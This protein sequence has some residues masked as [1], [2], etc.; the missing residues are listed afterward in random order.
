MEL[1]SVKED[2]VELGFLKDVRGLDV[3]IGG[4]NDFVITFNSAD[5]KENEALTE[6][7][8]W[9]ADGYG[10]VG[11]KIRCIKSSTGDRKVQASGYTWRGLLRKK[12]IEPDAGDDYKVVSGEAN[13]VL[14]EL[15]EPRFGGFYVVSDVDSGFQ[16][17]SHQFKRFEPLLDGI[18][19]MLYEVNA[20]LEISFVPGTFTG[21]TFNPGYVLIKAVPIID[22]SNEIE[23]SQDGKIDFTAK[24]YRMGVNHLVCL[25]QGELKDRQVVHLYMDADG[26]I[27]EEQSFFDVDEIV[28]VFDYSSAESL[29]DLISYGKKKLK[30]LGNYTTLKINLNDMDAQI[31]DIVGGQEQVTGITL[32]KQIAEII[33]KVDSKGKL[34]ITHKVGE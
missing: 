33:F 6:A 11:G 31:G 12:I 24:D 9:Y 18:V 21:N 23:Y 7:D 22:Y 8:F 5:W 4:S 29:E 10:E 28:E 16:I 3:S 14:A 20:K 17:E 32:K 19:D 1:I 27:S 2:G 34:Y 26:N 30:E 13:A 25:G 15:I